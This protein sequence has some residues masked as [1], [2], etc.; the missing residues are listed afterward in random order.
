MT[1]FPSSKNKGVLV[2]VDYLFSWQVVACSSGS[3]MQNG[4]VGDASY[5][6][7]CMYNVCV[8]LVMAVFASVVGNLRNGTKYAVHV[9]CSKSAYLL[10]QFH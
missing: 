7:I 8:W 6:R 2:V 10:K 5:I 4:F 3:G 9:I 1:T